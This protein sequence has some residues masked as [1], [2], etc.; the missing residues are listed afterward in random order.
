MTSFRLHERLLTDCHL[1]GRLVHCHVL[2]HRNA[3]LHWF[4]LVPE[5]AATDV[6]D[7]PATQRT[8]V[9]E[10]C[11]SVSACLKQ[12]LGYPKVNLGAIGNVVP[13]MHLHVVGRRPGD[14]V[15]PAPVWGPLGPG[16][17]YTEEELA[18]LRALLV[19]ACGMTPVQE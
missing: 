11:A 8:A 13:Q 19:E 15:W 5:T 4:I 18:G 16:P 6:L 17:A 7:L 9:L 14:A 10:E 1:L 12:R 3:A 2:L